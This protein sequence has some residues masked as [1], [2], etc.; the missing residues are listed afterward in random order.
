MG[1]RLLCTQKVGGSIPLVSTRTGSE[2]RILLDRLP[3]GCYAT[4][5][6]QGIASMTQTNAQGPV[7][8]ARTVLSI[9]TPG[10]FFR[11]K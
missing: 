8:Q 9:P 5:G 6:I 11:R 1:E 3:G 7:T 2:H 4:A 10:R